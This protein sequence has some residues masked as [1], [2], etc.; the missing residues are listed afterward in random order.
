MEFSFSISHFAMGISDRL[1]V[2]DLVTTLCQTGHH[3][4]AI[5]KRRRVGVLL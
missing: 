4:F 3:Y 5:A 2:V 1:Q